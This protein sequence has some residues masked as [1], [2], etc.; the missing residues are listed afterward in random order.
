MF[1]RNP[2][3]YDRDAA[4]KASGLVCEDESRAIQSQKKDADI[5]VLVKRYGLTGTIPQSFRPPTYQDFEGVF[6]FRTALHTVMAAEESFMSVPAEIR[7]RFQNDPQQFLEF[8]TDES[9]LD[10]MRKLGLAKP[11]QVEPSAPVP[12]P[13]PSAPASGGPS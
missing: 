8:C 10:E 1:I 13:G 2:Y 4:S 11:A 3:N 6:D 12:A 5:N 7:A 9:N